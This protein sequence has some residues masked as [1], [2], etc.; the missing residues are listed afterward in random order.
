MTYLRMRLEQVLRTASQLW[1]GHGEG[2][3]RN[4]QDIVCPILSQQLL[5][6]FPQ[7]TSTVCPNCGKN[8]PT[9]CYTCWSSDATK[10][11]PSREELANV[12]TDCKLYRAVTKDSV[13][14]E[15]L[16][17]RLIAWATGQETRRCETCRQEIT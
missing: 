8:P 3:P 2:C 17:D 6:C 14:W 4:H 16:L 11:Q 9:Y 15:V 12:L 1:F 5:A 10:R 7:P 13:D